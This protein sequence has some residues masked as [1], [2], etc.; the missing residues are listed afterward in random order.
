MGNSPSSENTSCFSCKCNNVNKASNLDF[1]PDS[2]DQPPK[3]YSKQKSTKTNV[4][5]FG[6]GK[7]TTEPH[8][9]SSLMQ[10]AIP[11]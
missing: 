5:S 1:E 8:K 3:V 4:M 9:E 10:S 7:R 6:S 11:I 2:K